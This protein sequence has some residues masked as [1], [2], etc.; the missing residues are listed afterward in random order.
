[1]KFS[2]RKVIIHFIAFTQMSLAMA[3]ETNEFPK[4]TLTPIQSV[5]FEAGEDGFVRCDGRT[6][7]QHKKTIQIVQEPCDCAGEGMMFHIYQDGQKVKTCKNGIEEGV[8]L[9]DETMGDLTI[10]PYLLNLNDEEMYSVSSE[11]SFGSCLLVQGNLMRT[12]ANPERK[13]FVANWEKY[14]DNAEEFYVDDL[15]NEKNDSI[16]EGLSL[17]DRK[18]YGRAVSAAIWSNE[19]GLVEKDFSKQQAMFELRALS[20]VGFDFDR[21]LVISGEEPLNLLKADITFKNVHGILELKEMLEKYSLKMND[22]KTGGVTVD[23]LIRLLNFRNYETGLFYTMMKIEIGIDAGYN[24]ID[25]FKSNLISRDQFQSFIRLYFKPKDVITNSNWNLLHVYKFSIAQ[26]KSD[27]IPLKNFVNDLNTDQ[28]KQLKDMYSFDEIY[29]ATKDLSRLVL[30]GL[31]AKTL[32][33]KFKLDDLSAYFSFQKLTE[34]YTLKEMLSERRHRRKYLEHFLANGES[35]KNL[36]NVGVTLNDLAY[37]GMYNSRYRIESRNLNQFHVELKETYTIEEFIEYER[38]S[39]HYGSYQALTTFFTLEELKEKGISLE[40]HL[41]R[42][43]HKDIVKLTELS[44]V[45]SVK[46]FLDLKDTYF[47]N[48]KLLKIIGF[49]ARDLAN[50]GFNRAELLEF[51]FSLSEIEMALG[52]EN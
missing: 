48:K 1:M 17:T 41:R 52:T 9:K 24:Y 21:L 18:I 47:L 22:L 3:V 7:S 44:K 36:K 19:C 23:Q 32:K 34:A 33:T 5:I 6:Y 25:F 2:Y 42:M 16:K 12:R 31:D 30:V 29:E 49:S 10:K 15:K 27:N 40:F 28:I 46:D 4:L 8:S 14:L 20:K 45:Y 38:N 43:F 35:L 39:A 50:H 37:V 51:G 26:L 13:E 11:Y